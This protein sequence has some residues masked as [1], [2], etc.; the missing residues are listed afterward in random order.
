MREG[1]AESRATATRNLHALLK[2]DPELR[3]LVVRLNGIGALISCLQRGPEDAQYQANL[4]LDILACDEDMKALMIG[5]GLAS[6]L[7]T[8]IATAGTKVLPNAMLLLS[9][10]VIFNYA[11]Q[12]TFGVA[13]V[14]PWLVKHVQSNVEDVQINAAGALWNIARKN[15]T[16]QLQIAT[17]G[18]L[19]PLIRLALSHVTINATGALWNIISVS[20]PEECL[21]ISDPRI[22]RILVQVYGD[23][24]GPTDPARVTDGSADGSKL[25]QE[26]RT[27]IVSALDTLLTINP[28]NV[29]GVVEVGALALITDIQSTDSENLLEHIVSVL[30]RALKAS[31][32]CKAEINAAKLV[33]RLIALLSRPLSTVAHA[34][35]DMVHPSEGALHILRALC[36]ASFD[37]QD[38]FVEHAGL[39]KLMTLLAAAPAL[40]GADARTVEACQ[41]EAMALLESFTRVHVGTSR[42]LLSSVG[43][44][45]LLAA[46]DNH[47]TA[48]TV[49]AAPTV[50]CIV[51]S[52]HNMCV[53]QPARTIAALL[54]RSTVWS[55]EPHSGV[56]VIVQTTRCAEVSEEAFEEVRAR[57]YAL[58]CTLAQ[59]SEAT[60]EACR[61]AIRD[62]GVLSS[63]D[64][65]CPGEV[66]R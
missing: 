40:D 32:Q 21:K 59:S 26:V 62:A 65:A 12:T 54:V 57:C 47:N 58:L 17:L 30:S 66:E 28:K 5:S 14:I 20:D 13:G 50:R 44:T 45:I 39:P 15:S 31:P 43:L 10:C 2:P 9:K 3:H 52:I 18:A 8:L 27:W 11:N 56:E 4:C 51:D 61:Q 48:V 37:A 55:I 36:D 34:N 33:P 46:L 23:Y 42:E 38:L 41:M 16:N 25:S 22:L 53:Q 24:V 19:L 64:F 29:E 60:S 49:L 1:T 6:P 63:A 35:R 7:V